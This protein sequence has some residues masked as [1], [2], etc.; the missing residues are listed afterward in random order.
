MAAVDH[1]LEI[2]REIEVLEGCFVTTRQL[3]LHL[4][5]E[6]AADYKRLAIEARTILDTELGA[7]NNFSH[8]ILLATS[9]GVGGFTGGPSRAS[10]VEVRKVIEGAVNHIRRRHGL[11]QGQIPAGKPAFVSGS[12]LAE[13]RGLP[14][15]RLDCARLVR[16]CEEL[17]VCYANG[18]YMAAVMVVRSIT[19]HIP[20]I[21]GCSNFSDVANNYAGAQSFR[22]SMKHLDGSLRHIANA[23]LHVH[24]R[25]SEA[26]PNESQ[27]SFQADLDVL[28]SEVVRVL[29]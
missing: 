17:N 3:G 10:V 26:L 12:R 27:V 4:K 8:N 9:T 28:L 20:P 23:H 6:D 15:T 14:K 7:L 5:S 19:D 24:I 2:T 11:A 16:L 13:L 18:C 1:L 22:G 29:K 21:F 25:K